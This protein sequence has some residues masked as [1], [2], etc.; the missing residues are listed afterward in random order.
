MTIKDL[1]KNPFGD[2]TLTK[3][4][5]YRNYLEVWLPTFIMQDQFR[6]IQIFDF[7]AGPG[8]DTSQRPG[9]P[10]LTLE[11]ILRFKNELDQKPTHTIL[12]LNEYKN[13]K[14]DSLKKNVSEFLKNHKELDPYLTVK[15]S[16]ED[17]E[18]SYIKVRDQFENG[19]PSL[20]FLDQNGIKFV[21]ESRFQEIIRFE[22]TDFL[23]FISSAHLYRF[24][25]HDSFL[26]HLNISQEDL[27]NSPY[28]TFHRTVVDHFRKL[29]PANSKFKIFPFSLK[30]GPNIH[31]LIFGASHI[32]AFC[33]FLEIAWKVNPINGDANFD[34]D[35]DFEKQASNELFQELKLK[36][37]IELFKDQLVNKIKSGSINNSLELFEFTIYSGHLPNHARDVINS[38][39]ADGTIRFSGNMPISYD[40][41]KRKERKTWELI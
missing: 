34:I 13:S 24:S 10:I 5:L 27:E 8:F 3:L 37:K 26:K 7:F 18:N 4:I 17:F 12:Y 23:F 36:T 31:G 28:R 19:F 32:A 1:H 40:A 41:Y 38:L 21:S 30:K 15:F 16:S 9:S 29:I 25:E 2:S 22:R 6:T 14:F 11:T 35:S 20:L 39:K 33:K